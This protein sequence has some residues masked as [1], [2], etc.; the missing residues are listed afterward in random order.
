MFFV[1]ES[2]TEDPEE[3]R[4]AVASF[5]S[6]LKPGAP[7]ATAFMAGS[8]GYPV[9]DTCFPALPITPDDV[10]LHLTELGAGELSVE[11]PSDEAPGTGGVRGDDRGYWSRR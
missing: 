1:A 2:I 10:R 11:T 6:A 7:F 8:H 3:F 9:A 5:V 4:A